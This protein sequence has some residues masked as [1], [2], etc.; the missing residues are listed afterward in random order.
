[1]T[2]SDEP[3]AQ[4]RN[5]ARLGLI[6]AGAVVVAVVV[7]LGVRAIL[8]VPHPT[9]GPVSAAELQLGACLEEPATDLAQYTVIDCSTAHPQQVFAAVDMRSDQDIYTEY[10]TIGAFV[11]EVCKRYLE[12]GLFVKGDVK[13]DAYDAVVIG[14]PAEAAFDAGDRQ[15]HCALISRDGDD[16]TADHYQQMP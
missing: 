10:S 7:I 11:D 5:W 2:A 4:Q 9:L 8:S 16:L 3:T 12:Y 14:L 15:A 6:A 13:N 1:M